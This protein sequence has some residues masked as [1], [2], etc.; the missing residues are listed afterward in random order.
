[1]TK[2][3]YQVIGVAS[4][5]GAQI[6]ACEEGPDTLKALDTLR[7]LPWEILYPPFQAKEKEVP[8]KDSL[9][10]ICDINNR[11]A[12]KVFQAMSAGHFP[13]VI[14]GDHSIAVGTWN[15][16]G[17]FFSKPFGLIWIDA[18]MD[19]HTPETTPSGAWHGMPLA[20]LLGRGDKKLT[21]LKRKTPLLKPQHLCLIGIRSFEEGEGQLLKQLGVKVYFM[22]DVQKRGFEPILK[23]AIE[24]VSKET[25]AYGISLDVDVIDPKEAPG[26]GSPEPGGILASELLKGLA[27]LNPDPRF[28]AFELVEFN[29]KRDIAHQTAHLCQQIL[30]T[31]L[32]PRKPS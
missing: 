21:E 32:F 8:L 11:L 18:H 20:A 3:I 10:L 24:I 28:K 19:S 9:P 26:V 12:D 1:V 31:V 30:A 17:Q 22:E 23:E 25:D 5:F 15:G 27:L 4:G 13:V 2:R 6:R 14:G 7:D 29:P 16:V